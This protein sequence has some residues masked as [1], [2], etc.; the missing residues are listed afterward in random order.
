MATPYN[1]YTSAGG[2]TGAKP[3]PTNRPQT[4]TNPSGSGSYAQ[5]GGGGSS[6]GGSS[7]GGSSGGGSSGGGGAPQSGQSW[8]TFGTYGNWA[9]EFA[10]VHGRM[11]NT[12]DSVDYWDSQFFAA[13]TGRAPDDG[14]WRNRYFSGAWDGKGAWIPRVGQD[15]YQMQDRWGRKAWIPVHGAD[16][17]S[18]N[19]WDR[20]SDI[21]NAPDNVREGAKQWMSQMANRNDAPDWL[22]T[23]ISSQVTQQ[24]SSSPVNIPGINAPLPVAPVDP[25]KI[26]QQG[27]EAVVID[28]VP[29]MASSGNTEEN[30]FG[31]L[32]GGRGGGISPVVTSDLSQQNPY[33]AS[34]QQV[35]ND[36][37]QL[38][39]SPLVQTPIQQTA[40]GLNQLGQNLSPLWATSTINQGQPMVVGLPHSGPDWSAPLAGANQ[41]LSPTEWARLQA[42]LPS[43][44]VRR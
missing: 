4:S 33:L 8:G 7:G 43:N 39:Q 25:T 34:G 37:S 15:G 40:Y 29:K 42:G 22:R 10:G 13:E 30:W 5:T 19:F 44:F 2:W 31:N 3:T 14:E 32:L 21:D 6:G 24:D 27:E 17:R 20:L 26:A 28:E 23:A 12:Q 18:A 9:Q 41:Q 1:P 35:L 11:P 38:W 36:L 16:A